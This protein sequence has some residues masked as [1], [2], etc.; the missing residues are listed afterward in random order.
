MGNAS[1][2]G[3][4]GDVFELDV[5]VV[6]RCDL[7]LALLYKFS[8]GKSDYSLDIVLIYMHV[9]VQQRLTYL[10]GAFHDMFAQK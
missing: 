4:D 9:K 10:Q 5:H 8:K 3:G 2:A 7:L 1:V 6:F